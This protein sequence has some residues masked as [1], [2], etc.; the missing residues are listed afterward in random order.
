MIDAPIILGAVAAILAGFALADRMRGD[1]GPLTPR[2]RAWLRTAAI[3]GGVSALLFF[4][5]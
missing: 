3:L 2:Q 1:G 4:G 5:R